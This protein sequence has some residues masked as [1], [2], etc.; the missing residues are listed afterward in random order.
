[1]LQSILLKIKESLKQEVNL[2]EK[3]FQ[4]L[5]TLLSFYNTGDLVYPGVI[6]R[7]LNVKMNEAYRILEILR[8]EGILE[9]NFEVY[10]HKCKKYTG[11]IFE[12]IGQIPEDFYC[13]E[14]DEPLDLSNNIIVIYK[15]LVE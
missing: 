13:D 10:C 9:L 7:K 2:N 3:Q 8:T 15:V 12:T 11:E 6:I 5:L 14:C 1:M 4:S